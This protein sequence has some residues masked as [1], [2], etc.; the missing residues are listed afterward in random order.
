MLLWPIS[1]HHAD[2]LAVDRGCGLAGRRGCGPYWTSMAVAAIPRRAALRGPLAVRVDGVTSLVTGLAGLTWSLAQHFEAA[3][4]EGYKITLTPD[5]LLGS[6]P[7]SIQP[8]S[9]VCGRGR[10][11]GWMESGLYESGLAGCDRSGGARLGGAARVEETDI[12][13][14]S[15]TP[16]ASTQPERHVGSDNRQRTATAR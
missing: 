3:P 11:L 9:D 1:V 14:A 12:A 4:R 16:G 10:N 6:G 13:A 2:H 7:L 15:A 5:Y 8:Q